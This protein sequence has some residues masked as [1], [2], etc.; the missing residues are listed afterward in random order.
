M[1]SSPFRRAA[2]AVVVVLAG[3]LASCA[4]KTREDA[5]PAAERSTVRPGKPWTKEFQTPSVLLADVVEIEGPE[6][7]VDHVATRVDPALHERRERTTPAGYLQEIERKQRDGE[8]DPLSEIQVY[9]DQM[10]IT[11]LRKVVILTRPG[12]VPVVVHARGNVFWSDTATNAERRGDALR[13]EGKL[14]K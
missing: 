14:E 9:L 4:G 11:A 1:K 6:G 3:A 5:P 13:F 2:F 10:Q 7:L 8:T 12:A